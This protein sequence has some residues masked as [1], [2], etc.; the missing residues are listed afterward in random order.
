MNYQEKII[1]YIDILGFSNKVRNTVDNNTKEEIESESNN[2]N[3][4]FDNVLELKRKY[5]HSENINSSRKISHFSDSIVISYLL[6]EEG[7]IF[8]LLTDILFLCITVLL[9]GYLIR[10]AISSGKLHHSENKLYGPALIYAYNMEKELASYP[11]IVF[12]KN[13]ITIAEKYLEKWPSKS[14]QLK[15]INK[16][17]EK[18][19]DGLYYLNYFSSIE[20]IFGAT[21]G[22]L[23]YLKAFKYKILDLKKNIEY[24]NSIKSKYLWLKEKY[25]I[26]LKNLKKKYL[27]EKIKIECSK[28]YEFLFNE[29][30]INEE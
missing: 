14:V 4:Y 30:E 7:G 26:A 11:R 21:N 2:I 13:I 10:G 22:L 19:F 6:E 25:N 12:E 16:L 15:A 9:D 28:L 5:I 23:V 20:Y 3:K 29:I 8:H 24:D 27:K 1:A 18:D 17:I